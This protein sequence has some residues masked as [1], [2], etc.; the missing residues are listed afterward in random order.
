MGTRFLRDTSLSD[1]AAIVGNRVRADARYKAA[2]ESIIE[3]IVRRCLALS[4]E[5]FRCAGGR[6]MIAAEEVLAFL[7]SCPAADVDVDLG[8]K[9][10]PLTV[11][12]AIE[13]DVASIATDARHREYAERNSER[14]TEAKRTAHVMDLLG[15]APTQADVDA[16]RRA[17]S[18]AVAALAAFSEAERAVTPRGLRADAA[19]DCAF[20]AEG[21]FA[22][23]LRA[24][25]RAV[26][27]LAEG[28]AVRVIEHINATTHTEVDARFVGVDS[29]GFVLFTSER[30]GPIEVHRLAPP[31]KF[32]MPTEERFRVERWVEAR[33][34]A[35]T[36]VANGPATGN[37]G[38]A[39]ATG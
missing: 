25:E 35:N 9:L 12:D 4:T 7:N 10:F 27:P 29:L 26:E 33:R 28:D 5:G 38:G 21:H 22:N 39:A 16:L 17:H 34:V 14:V 24:T 20:A 32:S 6:S 11:R 1:A 36:P 2:R 18:H 13:A 31:G 3:N 30:T 8:S 19:R 15:P 23:W 37:R